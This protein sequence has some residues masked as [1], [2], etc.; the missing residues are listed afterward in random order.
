[1]GLIS[2]L[3]E[4]VLYLYAALWV[5]NIQYGVTHGSHLHLPV[6]FKIIDRTVVISS[7]HYVGYG[8]HLSVIVHFVVASSEKGLVVN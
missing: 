4:I 6:S 2:A 7:Y 5:N 1:M 3:S 8:R